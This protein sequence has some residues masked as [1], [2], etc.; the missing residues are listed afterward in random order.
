MSRA[1]LLALVVVLTTAALAG[2]VEPAYVLGPEDVLAV[3]VLR[4]PEISRDLVMVLAD[5][6]IDYPMAGKIT[7]GGL[8]TTELAAKIEQGLAVELRKPE[9]TVTVTQPRTQRIYVDGQVAQGGVLNWKPGWR[10]SEALAAAGGLSIKPE[11]CKTTVFRVGRDP[12]PVDLVAI[13]MQQD[14]A[15]DLPLQPG[16][17]LH[18]AANTIT[19][20]VTG[21]VT[22]NGAFE[23]LVGSTTRQAIAAAGGV[24]TTASP[25]QAYIMRGTQKIPV[26]LYRVLEQGDNSADVVL[27]PGDVIHV[28]ENRDNIA[29]FGHIQKPGYFTIRPTDHLT[30]SQAIAQA[31]GTTE[32]AASS[33]VMLIREQGGQSVTIT[34]D[35]RAIL[36]R[37]EVSKDVEV[38]AG[39]RILVP[40]SP[41]R[42]PARMLSDFYGLGMLG[43]LFL[44]L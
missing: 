8:T 9:V 42:T 44:G 1:C 5:G 3:V 6:T 34:V 39:D 35:L 38:R 15:A 25:E 19:V 21:N 11:R 20:Y 36:E 7:A 33:N 29:V 37:G 27:Q 24:P 26:D 31:G 41:K 18:V 14:P 2:A 30:V 40:N 22:Q 43:R 4:H 12:I 28:P 32:N 13:F 10:V 17:S 16:D 23:V